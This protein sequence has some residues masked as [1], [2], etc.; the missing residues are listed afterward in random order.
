MLPNCNA[1]ASTDHD[2]KAAAILQDLDSLT[3][4]TFEFWQQ[5]GLDAK[6]GGIHSTLDKAGQSIEP[7]NKGIVQTARHVYA[8]SIYHKY[9]PNQS[10]SPSP[11]EMADSAYE[12]L[13]SNHLDKDSGL[14]HW[15]ATREGDVFQ[16]NKV[17]YGQWFAIYALSTYADVFSSQEALEAALACFQGMDKAGWHD[18]ISG[19]YKELISNSIPGSAPSGVVDPLPVT[20]NTILHGIEAL[21]QLLI[22]LNKMTNSKDSSS[23]ERLLEL[24]RIA[25]TQLI[26][27]E[28]YIMTS[29]TPSPPGQ[30]WTPTES[31]SLDYGHVLEA[32]WLVSDTLDYLLSTDSIAPDLAGSY[33]AAVMAAAEKTIRGGGYDTTY[34][35]L[36]EVEEL[37]PSATSSAGEGNSTR[38]LDVDSSPKFRGK[39]WWV[40][41]ETCLGL[42]SLYVYS[43]QEEFYLDLLG[44]TVTFIRDY[45][46]DQEH[47]EW[48]WGV[49]ESGTPPL[50]SHPNKGNEWKASYHTLRMLLLLTE[51]VASG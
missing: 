12:F 44:D 7:E 51:R 38:N 26:T 5:H 16:D 48:F 21:S 20:F 33:K 42:W 28:G 3:K 29:Y 22:S 17:L 32:T 11:K 34:G 18:P 1:M 10:G 19:G 50:A 8:F 39:I 4:S 40:Q 46:N 36:Y 41:A 2:S 9:H 24:I 43:G 15:M 47:G 13:M 6:Y 37:A 23:L 25:S 30:P 14:F 35:G 49:A 45:L 31:A 27:P